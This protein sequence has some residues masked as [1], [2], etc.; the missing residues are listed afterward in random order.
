MEICLCWH[1]FVIP[2][3][4]GLQPALGPFFRGARDR[5]EKSILPAIL[6]DQA[7]EVKQEAFIAAYDALMAGLG[8]DEMV[9]SSDALHP[10]QQS[11]PAHGWFPKGQ[12]TA[13]KSSLGVG[14]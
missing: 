14:G 3:I 11:R 10:T 5:F 2:R 8:D 12:N 6:P 7:D 4:K 9:V 1:R 13:L